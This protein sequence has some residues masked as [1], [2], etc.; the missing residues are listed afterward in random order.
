MSYFD[1]V[2]VDARKP[3]IMYHNIELFPLYRRGKIRETGCPTLILLLLMLESLF[4]LML[5]RYHAP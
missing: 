4:S 5:A 2:V 3:L 1:Y